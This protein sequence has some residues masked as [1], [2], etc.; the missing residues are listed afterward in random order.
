MSKVNSNFADFELKKS[1]VY[2]LKYPSN[3][4]KADI[5]KIL[6]SNK[7]SYGKKGFRYFTGY[8]NGKKINHCV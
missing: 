6:I 2:N 4:D 7:V 3:I 1:A 5:T 8:Q